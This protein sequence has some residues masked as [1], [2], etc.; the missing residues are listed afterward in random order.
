MHKVYCVSD[1][2]TGILESNICDFTGVYPAYRV[3]DALCRRVS[4][5]CRVVN[6][7]FHAFAGNVLGM[8]VAHDEA[9]FSLGRPVYR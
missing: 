2:W 4:R 8:A 7:L 5:M 3:L 6:Y 1:A 9:E